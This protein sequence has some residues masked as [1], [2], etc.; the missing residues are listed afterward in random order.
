MLSL[1]ETLSGEDISLYHRRSDPSDRRLYRDQHLF[2]DKNEKSGAAADVR[3]DA[4]VLVDR[5]YHHPL[6]HEIQKN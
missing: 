3:G 4:R 1:S 5:I 2:N 6:F